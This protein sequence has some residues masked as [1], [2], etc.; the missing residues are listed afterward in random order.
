MNA[1]PRR[2]QSWLSL[3]V[4]VG[5]VWGGHQ[6]WSQWREHRD[7]HAIRATARAQ[8]IVMFTTDDCPYCAKAR[9][10]FKANE[11]PW[12]ECNIERNALCKQ[13]FDARGAPGVP[14]LHVRGQWQLGFDPAWLAKALAPAPRQH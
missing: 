2:P 12:R 3:V 9:T 11:V 6:V 7:I 14:L 5:V 1:T 8:D 10:W 4:I 13:V